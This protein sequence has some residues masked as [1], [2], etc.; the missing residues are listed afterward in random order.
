MQVS[1]WVLIGT[2]LLLAAVAFLAPY[3]IEVWKHKYHSA[4]LNFKFSHTPPYSHITQM[5]GIG[6]NFPIYYFRFKVVNHGRI[7]AE[8]CEVVLERIWKRN[9]AGKLKE[10]IGFSPVALKWSS[11]Q[12]VGNPTI[13]PGRE[14]FCNIGCIYQP[15]YEP[16]SVY[17]SISEEEKAQRKFFLELSEKYFAQWDCL[18]PGKYQIEVTVYSKNAVKNSRRFN[19]AWSGAWKEKEAE[20]LDELVIY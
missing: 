14:L 6:V 3:V 9:S 16:E 18:I 12:M 1:E 20:M 7:Q 13:Q 10:F 5:R 8:Q 19:I 15:D 17:R 11:P 2:T 4:K